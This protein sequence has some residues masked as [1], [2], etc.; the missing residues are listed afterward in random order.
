M[1]TARIDLHLHLDGSLNLKWVYD[2]AIR[3]GAISDGTSFEDFYHIVYANNTKDRALSIR[4]FELMCDVLQYRED[5]VEATRDLV[6]TLWQEGIYY[7]EI[8]F[9][10][11]QHTSRGL[12]QLDALKAV[13]DGAGDAMDRYPGI[14]IGIINCLMHKG[15]SA[16]ANMDENFET[17]RVTKEMLGK[18]AVGLDLAGFENNGDFLAYAPLFAEACRL[19]IPY[20]IHAGEMGIGEHVLDALSMG[21]DRIGHGVN[22]VQDQSYLD[23]VLDSHIPLE[24]CVS[25]NVKRDLDYAAHPVRFLIDQGANITINTDNRIFARTNTLNEHALLRMIGVTEEQ[26]SQ[27]TFNAAQAAFCDDETREWLLDRLEEDLRKG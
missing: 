6:Q 13:I 23:A 27:C 26:L 17:I 19:G 11:Q 7:A 10:S 18:G 25:S 15:D 2:R 12:S 8:R 9:A 3:Y 14:R 22:C 21:A 20:T 5:L 16:A 24:V 4:K 1:Q